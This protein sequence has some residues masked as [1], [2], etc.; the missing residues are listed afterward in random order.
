MLSDERYSMTR[1]ANR[2]VVSDPVCRALS[3]RFTCHGAA[4]ADVFANNAREHVREQRSR[5]RQS[6][7]I[8][9]LRTR[10]VSLK[11]ERYG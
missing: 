7:D 10:V 9:R 2:R 5:T 4:F 3:P 6:F 1:V 8:D 11:I